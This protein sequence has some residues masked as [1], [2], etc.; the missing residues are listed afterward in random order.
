MMGFSLRYAVCFFVAIYLF[1]DFYACRGPLYRQMHPPAIW[2]ARVHGRGVT[3]LELEEAMRDHLWRRGEKWI[4]LSTEAQNKTRWLV[5]ESL[6]NDRLVRAF[7]LMGGEVRS[8]EASSAKD[9]HRLFKKQF[10][11]EGDYRDRL[12]LHQLTE[13][14]FKNEIQ[15]ENDDLAWIEECISDRTRKVTEAD[16]KSWYERNKESLMIPVSY[17]ASHLF[18]TRHDLKKGGREKEIREI[19][20]KLVSGEERFEEMVALHSEDE[21]SKSIGGDLGWC[22]SDRMPKEVVAAMAKLEFGKLSEPVLSGLGWHLLIVRERKGQRLPAFEEVR[23]EI[24]GALQT[25]VRKSAMT[26][27]FDELRSKSVNPNR[28]LE[29]YPDVIGRAVP[30]QMPN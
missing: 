1:V 3:L 13:D 17:R 9:E 20:R 15:A 11:K 30:A 23:T 21:R 12:T 25:E 22:S 27:L 24:L 29:S 2:V 14:E 8:V 28:F 4:E 7:R 10:E 19:Y 16:A 6:V 18:L 5:L 26:S